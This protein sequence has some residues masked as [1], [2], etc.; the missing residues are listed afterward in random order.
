MVFSFLFH[1]HEGLI[2]GLPIL[3]LLNTQFGLLMAPQPI[4]NLNVLDRRIVNYIAEAI[5]DGC[6]D[7]GCHSTR[8][9][10][11]EVRLGEAV[12]VGV[13]VRAT[14]IRLQARTGFE[15]GRLAVRWG[16][17]AD[18]SGVLAVCCEGVAGLA[19]RGSGLGKIRPSHIII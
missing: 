18:S 14:L 6:L 13:G 19:E 2:H 1:F 5:V 11:C 16:G 17:V 15:M 12:G 3:T 10:G 7:G 9:L 8:A 4:P